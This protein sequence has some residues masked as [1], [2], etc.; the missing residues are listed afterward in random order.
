MKVFITGAG[1]LVGSAVTKELIAHG[2]TV[3]GLARSD[4]SGANITANGGTFVQGDITNLDLVKQLASD[5]DATIHC[6]FDNSF[7]DFPKACAEDRDVLDTVGAV[8]VGTDKVLLTC[9]GALIVAGVPGADEDT[10]VPAAMGAFNPRVQSEILALEWAAKGVRVGIMRLPP[11]V[12]HP[13][14]MNH[15]FILLI[16]GA[17][18]KAGYVAVIEGDD[19]VTWSAVNVLDLAVLFRLALDKT[20]GGMHWHPAGDSAIKISD[21]AAIASKK[22][23]IPLKTIPKAEAG[24]HFGIIGHFLGVGAPFPTEKTKERTGWTVTQP[25]LLEELEKGAYFDK[26]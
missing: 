20:Q 19:N 6:A 12:H 8:Y 11:M 9:S 1:G 4:A 26:I 3:V 17:H 15:G 14:L 7:T 24:A 22:L 5:A 23:D 13:K 18:K 2:H 16:L 21:I 25:G 10:P